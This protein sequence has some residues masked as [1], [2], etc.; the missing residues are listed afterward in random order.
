MGRYVPAPQ[1]TKENNS[2]PYANPQPLI[3]VRLEASRML[4]RDWR[5]PYIRT[6]D[7]FPQVPIFFRSQSVR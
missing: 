5:G 3:D 1:F 4:G 6:E 7:P 2:V